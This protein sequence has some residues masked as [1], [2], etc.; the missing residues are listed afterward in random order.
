M[1]SR[2]AEDD[3]VVLARTIDGDRVLTARATFASTQ[4]V[5]VSLDVATQG[6]EELME[7]AREGRVYDLYGN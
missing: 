7:V 5:L 3:T 2:S 4:S 6:F 1:E